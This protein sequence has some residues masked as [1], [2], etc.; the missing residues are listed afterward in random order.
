M[1]KSY[2]DQNQINNEIDEYVNMQ[3]D[4][5]LEMERTLVILFEDF[6]GTRTV[7]NKI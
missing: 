3:Y 4:W 5:N 7:T 6:Y 1:H 2:E